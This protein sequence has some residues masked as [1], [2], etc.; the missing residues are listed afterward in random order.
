MSDELSLT[1]VIADP[2][3][4]DIAQ[5]EPT[6]P[7][8]TAAKINA[9]YPYLQWIGASY[10]PAEFN[11]FA[12]KGYGDIAKECGVSETQVKTLHEQYQAAIQPEQ[13]VVPVSQPA[14]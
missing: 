14:E 13:P 11:K 5:P 6:E 7:N 1:D 8:L 3:A 10:I 12:G 4:P 9:V 2:A